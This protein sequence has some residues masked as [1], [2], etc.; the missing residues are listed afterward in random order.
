MKLKSNVHACAQTFKIEAPVCRSN[1]AARKGLLEIGGISHIHYLLGLASCI[2]LVSAL[3][4]FGQSPDQQ[5]EPKAGTWKTWAISSGKDFRVPPPPDAAATLAELAVLKAFSQAQDSGIDDQVRFWNAGPPS[6]RWVDVVTSR[7]IDPTQT[8]IGAFPTRAYLYVALATYD[9]TIAAWDSKYAFNRK[10]PNE[11]DPTIKP[12][13][14]VPRS[15]SYPSDYAATAFAAADV[16]AYFNPSEADSF[17]IMAEEA[18]Q[19]R[20]YAGVEFI[21]DYKAGM[22]LGHRVAEKVIA[23]AKADGSDA[24]W[25]GSVPSGPCMW[26]GTNPG[27]VTMPGW[28]PML[29]ASTSDFRPTP[30]PACDSPQGQA[31]MANVSNFP[32]AL[33]TANFL[34]NAKAFF[35]QSPA[36]LVPWV[37]AYLNR[38]ILEDGLAANPPRAAR[39]YALVGVGTYDAFLGSQ[40][41]KFTYWY[42]RPAQLDTSLVPLFPAP[43]FPSYP[44]NHATISGVRGELV[45]YLFPA[46]ADEI[47]A[48]AKEAADSRVWAGIH[49]QMDLDAGLALGS[50]VAQRVI[51]WA[52]SDGSQ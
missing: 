3:P 9:A 31:E 50:K 48:V 6:Y 39:V 14:D 42:L 35:W 26:T 17:R 52:S 5:V 18:A 38:W 4:A 43:N 37:Y 27:N 1:H 30:P 51:S 47:R 34:T 2:V 28:K 10:R 22:E 44:S 8:P 20:L 15:P 29:L 12:R 16:L 23:L 25:T 7:L 40:D 36:G 41:G 32:R 19:S 49:Y 24:P 11:I 46:H 45:A 21:S 33:N 13:V